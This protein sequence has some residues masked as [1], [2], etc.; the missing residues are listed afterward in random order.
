MNLSNSSGSYRTTIENHIKAFDKL[1][2]SARRAMANAKLDWAGQPFLRVWRKGGFKTGPD[3]AKHIEYTDEQIVRRE[4]RKVWGADYP[5][6]LPAATR[7]R[8]R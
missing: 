2:P 3:L 1:P 4:L 7:R 8:K 5:G 6:A